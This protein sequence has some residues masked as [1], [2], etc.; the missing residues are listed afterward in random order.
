MRE[1]VL[2]RPSD[3]Q[4]LPQP[5]VRLAYPSLLHLRRLHSARRWRCAGDGH[6]SEVEANV[7]DGARV[8]V[9]RSL[10]C[11]ATAFTNHAACAVPSTDDVQ[12]GRKTHHLYGNV[13]ARVSK[14]VVR[15]DQQL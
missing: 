11:A 12:G 1:C 8:P 14:H 9:E 3:E 4:L 10:W 2:E 6:G 5:S 7:A 13:E 15:V